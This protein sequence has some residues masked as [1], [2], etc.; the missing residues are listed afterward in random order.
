M[1]NRGHRLYQCDECK[2]K[3]YHHWIEL[4]RAARMRCPGCGS[5]RLELVTE[6]GKQDQALL[7]QVSVAGH[8]DMIKP[9]GKNNKKIT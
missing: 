9:K 1:A 8:R 2:E 7:Q 6:A 5:A 4:N 3:S